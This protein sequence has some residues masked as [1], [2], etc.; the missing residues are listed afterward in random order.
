MVPGPALLSAWSVR[1]RRAAAAA[2][3]PALALGALAVPLPRAEAQEAEPAE[4]TTWWQDQPHTLSPRVEVLAPLEWGDQDHPIVPVAVRVQ[5]P[6]G[7]AALV[8][9][10]ATVDDEPPVLLSHDLLTGTHRGE[11]DLTDLEEGTHHLTLRAVDPTGRYTALAGTIRGI[12]RPKI[13]LLGDDWPEG[14]VP[15]VYGDVPVQ[16]RASDPQTPPEQLVVRVGPA[17]EDGGGYPFDLGAVSQPLTYDPVSG[18]FVGTYD[19]TTAPDDSYP[20]P[21]GRYSGW[22]LVAEVTDEDGLQ[23]STGGRWLVPDNDPVGWI[24]EPRSYDTL[25]GTVPVEIFA[26]KAEAA[27]SDAGIAVRWWVDDGTRRSA[28]VVAGSADRRYLGQLDTTTLPDGVHHLFVEV[29]DPAVDRTYTS[30]GLRVF[31][32]NVGPPT[33]PPPPPPPP[34]DPEPASGFLP[35]GPLR[36]LDTRPGLTV[37]PTGGIPKAGRVVRLPIPDRASLGLPP[38]Q[39]AAV[40]LSVT[41]TQPAGAGWVTAWPCSASAP[42]AST[43]NV[44]GPGE[45]VAN[46]ALVPPGTTREV[47]LYTSAPMHLVVDLTGVVPTTTGFTAQSPR[48][49]L[50]TRTSGIRPAGSVTA[51]NLAGRGGV[52]TGASQVALNVTATGASGPGWVTVAS[53]AE[54]DDPNLGRRASSLNVDR[55]GQTVAN[56]V[57]SELDGAGQVCLFSSAATH[58]VVDV[59]GSWARDHLD[60]RVG[61]RRLLDTRL[62]PGRPVA[63]GGT[64]T[65][66]TNLGSGTSAVFNVT[67]TG[68]TGPGYATVWPCGAP[69]PPTSNVNLYRAGQTAAAGVAT[70]TGTAGALCVHVSGGGHVIVD[71][72]GRFLR[73][74][75]TSPI[76]QAQGQSQ[77]QSEPNPVVPA[78][79]ISDPTEWG[80]GHP[81]V[82]TRDPASDV[83]YLN[84]QGM[85]HTLVTHRW[86]GEQVG[87]LVFEEHE[88]WGSAT[89]DGSHLSLDYELF[90]S[91]GTW[92]RHFSHWNFADDNRHACDLDYQYYAQP[93]GA[94]FQLNVT[95]LENQEVAIARLPAGWP[96]LLSCSVRHDRAVVTVSPQGLPRQVVVVRLS[97]GAILPTPEG[98]AAGYEVTADGRFLVSGGAVGQPTTVCDLDTGATVR[99]LPYDRWPEL[100]GDGTLALVDGWD[101]RCGWWRERTLIDLAT[102]DQVWSSTEPGFEL[103]CD[104]LYTMPATHDASARALL[105]VVTVNDISKPPGDVFIV[106]DDGR[107]QRVWE[108]AAYARVFAGNLR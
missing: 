71:L 15:D 50:D 31:V 43:L 67:V 23:A 55:A 91:D 63:R 53:C 93:W 35:A 66:P 7:L 108:D 57:V 21:G 20:L 19:S 95:D 56:L 40:A 61:P 29:V 52:N 90:G 102:G 101:D 28:T 37:G 78:Q 73:T 65:V 105:Q 17:V 14:G 87:V 99:T 106:D 41:A 48:R 70:A 80:L 11:V 59:V 85:E 58:L 82:P 89:P 45:T 38:G 83:F 8:K 107:P 76:V 74:G 2:L 88:G 16:V 104:E 69:R 22:P 24:S 103:P 6:D 3:V 68:A 27:P 42:L 36:L 92:Q 10:S 60:T 75:T 81:E 33:P 54:A 51:I 46:L 18:L 86:D 34:P 4:A 12:L 39:D 1:L 77:G 96:Q 64:V 49:V 44:G 97:D 30:G 25:T 9:V 26:R 79:I 98:C 13:E 47:C 5:D 100:N 32:D 62:S 84:P 72:V 94:P